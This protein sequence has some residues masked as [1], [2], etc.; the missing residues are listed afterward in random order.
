MIELSDRF[1]CA[2]DEVWRLQRGSEADCVF[3]QRMVNGGKR[4]TDRGSR[5]GTWLCAP[6]GVVLARVN[7]RDTEKVLATMERALA[8][9]EELPEEQRHVPA[10]ADLE[11]RKR[12]EDSFPEQGLVLE[13]IARE[14][15]TEGLARTPHARWN[16]DF[17]W[18][19][20]SEVRAWIPE[21]A[22]VGDVIRLPLVARR[23]ARFHLVDNVRGQTL[24]FADEEVQ[25][26]ILNALVT[27][28]EGSLLSL[29]LQGRTLAAAAGAWLLGENLWKPSRD[30]PHGI[31]CGLMGEARFDLAQGTFQTFELVAIGRRWG[32]TQMNGRGRD[33]APGLIGFHLELAPS[34]P[35]I[36]PT[37]VV[38]YGVDW[39]VPPGLPT[40][41]DSPAE[42]G[43]EED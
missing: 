2:A 41:V 16:R 11:S 10:D 29:S 26:A 12:W 17:A 8:A 1:V 34:A 32:H 22:E 6:G 9:W 25:E 40:W 28:R 30:I 4:I 31:Q 38:A 35:R 13:R 3:F 19:S 27:A 42:C 24:P 7:S 5:Q 21:D 37:F 39:I 36:A 14:L 20:G 33:D 23:L 18:F 43:L 15:T